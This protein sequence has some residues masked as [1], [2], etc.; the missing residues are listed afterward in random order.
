MFEPDVPHYSNSFY[1]AYLTLH[2][3][4]KLSYIMGEINEEEYT[5]YCHD[6]QCFFNIFPREE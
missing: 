6:I 4:Y 1:R 5:Q 2:N 3:R